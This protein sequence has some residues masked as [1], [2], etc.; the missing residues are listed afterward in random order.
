MGVIFWLLFR[1][2]AYLQAGLAA[3]EGI[4]ATGGEEGVDGHHQA[5][6]GR[7]L[8]TAWQMARV[9]TRGEESQLDS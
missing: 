5:V 2:G 4:P 6:R 1:G 8:L 7:R 3:H 9:M